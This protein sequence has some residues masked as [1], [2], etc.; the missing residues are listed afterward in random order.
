MKKEQQIESILNSLEGIERSSPEPFF[1]TRLQARMQPAS[2]LIEKIIYIVSRPAVAFVTIAIIVLINT[3]AIVATNAESAN[4]QVTS[5]EIATV[6]E[7]MQV[8][9]NLFDTE[10]SNP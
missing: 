8:S 10:K 7:Y 2:S 3:F 5:A 1:Y 6:D 4:D 9:A